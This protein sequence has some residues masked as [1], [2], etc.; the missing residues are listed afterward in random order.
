MYLGFVETLKVLVSILVGFESSAKL[1]GG[2]KRV[3]TF[4]P[5]GGKMNPF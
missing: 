1:R 3:L 5:T 4:T 2:F